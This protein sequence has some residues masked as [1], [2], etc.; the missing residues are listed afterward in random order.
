M[1]KEQAIE[2]L[3]EE[4]K[5]GDTLWT[6]LKHVSKSGMTRHIA[7]RFLKDN[8]PYDYTYLVAKALDGKISDKYDGIKREGCGMDMGFDLIYNLSYV[9]HGDG[10]AI[11]Q[12]WL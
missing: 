8:Y 10:Y 5:E 4:I 6:Q 9:L 11:N 7:V 12:R 1:N 2:K 3:R